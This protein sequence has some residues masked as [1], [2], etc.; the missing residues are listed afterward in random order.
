MFS[1][2]PE[3]SFVDGQSI[4]KTTIRDAMVVPHQPIA[5]RIGVKPDARH[6]GGFNLFGRSFGNYAQDLL[7]RLHYVPR[8]DSRRPER[9]ESTAVPMRP[10]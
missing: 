10:E 7:L 5:V 1:V 2:T 8:A 3:G 6:A 9:P 4:S